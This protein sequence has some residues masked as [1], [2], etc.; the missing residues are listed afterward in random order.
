MDWLETAFLWLRVI[1]CIILK[2]F[3]ADIRMM[4]LSQRHFPKMVCLKSQ[5]LSEDQCVSMAQRTS[6]TGFL[7]VTPHSLWKSGLAKGE[8]KYEEMGD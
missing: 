2:S 5:L 4:D 3:L 7:K 8:G 6:H 1:K